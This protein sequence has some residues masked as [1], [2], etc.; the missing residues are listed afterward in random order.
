MVQ[1]LN[2]G[3]RTMSFECRVAIATL[4][5]FY[6]FVF[7]FAL[8]P[9]VPSLQVKRSRDPWQRSPTTP[10]NM[11]PIR[12]LSSPTLMEGITLTSLTEEEA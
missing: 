3:F 6:V 4:V 12:S 9:S 5:F 1:S 7:L 8:S 10:T 2:P 11:T